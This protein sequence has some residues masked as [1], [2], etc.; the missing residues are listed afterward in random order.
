M[1]KID[2]LNVDMLTLICKEGGLTSSDLV[3]RIYPEVADRREFQDKDAFLRSRLV[4]WRKL[5]VLNKNGSKYSANEEKIQFSG[6][7]LQLWDG[8]K[9][10]YVVVDDGGELASKIKSAIGTAFSSD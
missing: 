9:L 2:N 5:G 1:I 3:K 8:E 7:V 10:L 6:G 4:R